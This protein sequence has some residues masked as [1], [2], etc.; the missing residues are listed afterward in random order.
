MGS[1]YSGP[2][3]N[4]EAGPARKEAQMNIKTSL[5][6]VA[7]LLAFGSAQAQNLIVNG[8]F[9]N[10][11]IALGAFDYVQNSDWGNAGAQALGWSLAADTGAG[12]VNRDGSGWA[13]QGMGTGSAVAFL[14]D[15]PAF[16]GMAPQLSQSFFSSASSFVVS[17]DL[18]QRR[19]NAAGDNTQ[20]VIVKLDGQMLGG[21]ALVPADDLGAHAYSFAISGLSGT[22]HTLT[23]TSAFS[24]GDQ[25]AFID[26]VSVTAAVPEPSTYALMG[27]GLLGMAGLRR[28]RQQG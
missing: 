2:V 16:A 15:H 4:E 12:I 14:Q 17:F 8:D 5:V 20:D 25:T 24:S 6:A 22:S 27:L 10:N 26:N 19:W 11:N 28:R 9:E 21:A 23:F 1:A 3:Y 18:G 13:W 7:A